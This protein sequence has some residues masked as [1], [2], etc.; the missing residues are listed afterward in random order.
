[1]AKPLLII[2]SIILLLPGLFYTVLPHSLHINIAP[3]WLIGLNFPHGV[4]VFAIGMP[5]II[6]GV[7]LLSIGLMRR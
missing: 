1:M 7:V 2:L 3:D 4:H 6:I 5:L